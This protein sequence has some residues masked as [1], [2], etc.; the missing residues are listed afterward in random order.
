MVE[1]RG[2]VVQNVA[3]EL[4]ERDDKLER[5]AERMVHGDQVGGDE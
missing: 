3:V 4:A 5:V 2:C 1:K